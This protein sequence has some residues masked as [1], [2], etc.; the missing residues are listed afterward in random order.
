MLPFSRMLGY[1]T[2][3]ATAR[4]VGLGYYPGNV[5]ATPLSGAIA[6]HRLYDSVLTDAMIN[7]IYNYELSGGV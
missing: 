1:G 7:N 6:G 4:S 2:G 5:T 3:T